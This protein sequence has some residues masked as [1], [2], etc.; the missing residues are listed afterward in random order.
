MRKHQESVGP[1][2]VFLHRKVRSNFS[3]SSLTEIEAERLE[4]RIY[5]IGI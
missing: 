2:R 5:R 4:V 3:T 1:T